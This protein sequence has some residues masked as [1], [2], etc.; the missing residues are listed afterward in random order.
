MPDRNRYRHLPEGDRFIDDRQPGPSGVTDATL[1]AGQIVASLLFLYF[2][3]F[4][5]PFTPIWTGGDEVIFLHDAAR[6][7]DGQVLYRDFAQMT[8][9]ATD[10]LYLTAFKVFGLQM[11]IPNFFLVLLG[12]S[13]SYLSYFITKRVVPGYTALLA[14]LLFL[15]MV[16]R[17]RLDATHHW[18][19]ALATLAALAVLIDRRTQL[20]V[21]LAGALC[22]IAA[23]FTQSLGFLALLALGLFLYWEARRFLIPAEEMIKKQLLLAACFAFVLGACIL[24]SI[25]AVGWRAFIHSTLIFSLRYYPALA[26]ANNFQVYMAGLGGFL[27]WQRIPDLL[28]FILIHALLPLIYILFLVRHHRDSSQN[29]AQPW[30][31][32]MLINFVGVFSLLSVVAAPTWARL[33]YVSLP[34]LILFVWFLRPEGPG[35][36]ASSRLLLGYTTILLVALPLAKQLHHPSYL[37]LPTGRVAFLNPDA[38]DRYRWASSKTQP[39]DYFFGGLFPDFYFI[40]KL[41]NPAPVAFVTPYEYTRPEEVQ[42]VLAGLEQHHVKTLLWVPALDLPTNPQGDHLPPLRRYIR[43]HYHVSS[44]LPEYDVWTRND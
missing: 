8:F 31:A 34:A 27:H 41:R 44:T 42:A 9:P 19:S 10:L 35:G 16:F 5:P 33:Y 38:Y 2:H 6:M 32:L 28:G 39:S 18:F 1:T 36:Q 26:G 22:G 15:T 24:P 12:A 25:H 21:S 20:R 37:N 40:L 7:L 13:L 4:I 17:N 23:A 30:D 29:T 11:W 14:P 3:L 43:E